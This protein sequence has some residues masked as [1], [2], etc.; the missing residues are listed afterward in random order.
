MKVFAGE[1]CFHHEL[2]A[3]SYHPQFSINNDENQLEEN[4][5]CDD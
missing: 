3:T 2:Q 5:F 1:F 4:D